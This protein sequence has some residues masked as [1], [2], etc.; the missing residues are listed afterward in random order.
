MGV[1]YDRGKEKIGVGW[2]ENNEILDLDSNLPG[3][4]LCSSPKKRFLHPSGWSS[5]K[6]AT[7]K[8]NR[9]WS[10][11][12]DISI[13]MG[14]IFFRFKSEKKGGV[15]GGEAERGDRSLDVRSG[16]LRRSLRAVECSR[17]GP[18]ACPLC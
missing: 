17:N 10:C 16:N 5:Q 11:F 6:K 14:R 4:K 18:T 13:G 7:P 8:R 2:E 3:W 15:G 12:S 9:I 1:S